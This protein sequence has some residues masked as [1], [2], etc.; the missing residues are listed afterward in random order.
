MLQEPLFFQETL[1]EI[2][3]EIELHQD[4]AKH[5][6]QV[7]R[8]QRGDKLALTNGKG[9]R[10]DAIITQVHKRHCSVNIEQVSD[11]PRVEPALHLAVAFTKNTNRNEW[12]LEKITELGVATII[13]VSSTRS[14]REKFR[15]DRFQ[16]ILIAAMLQSQQY[17]L[18]HLRELT[19]LA[20]VMSE[21]SGLPQKLVAH[22]MAEKE[23]TGILQAIKKSKETLLLI[24]PEGDFSEEEVNDL[25]SEGYEGIA[26]GINRLRTETAAVNAC[27][28]FNMVNH[29]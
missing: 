28:V 13:P 29:G 25:T 3:G 5:V 1:P 19:P 15:Y 22:C 17:Y 21:Y 4:T 24:G 23:R 11:Y 2:P 10:A 6:V 7:L 27:A 12:L 20:D 16:N 18:P 9:R 26:M 14:E 8:M